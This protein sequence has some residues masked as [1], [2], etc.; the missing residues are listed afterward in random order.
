MQIEEESHTVGEKALAEKK[1][2]TGKKLSKEF[3]AGDKKNRT[4]KSLEGKI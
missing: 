4:K 3:G 1:P 2:K